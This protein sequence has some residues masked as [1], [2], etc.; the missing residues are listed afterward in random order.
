MGRY[1]DQRLAG[2]TQLGRATNWQA[3]LEDPRIGCP[4]A[5]YRTPYID[6][7]DPYYR[8][9]DGN[10]GRIENPR[11]DAADWQIQKA[12]MLIE[13]EEERWHRYISNEQHQRAQKRAE[14]LAEENA[15][16]GRGWRR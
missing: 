15:A 5:W 2:T 6:S 13:E 7:L 11:F 10:G 1:P 3:P 14:K 9:R 8:R 4:G 16:K 12:I